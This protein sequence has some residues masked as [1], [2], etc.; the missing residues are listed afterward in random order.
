VS[1]LAAGQEAMISTAQLAS[2]GLGSAAIVRRVRHGLLHRAAELVEPTA[3]KL[4]PT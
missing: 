3:A 2:A 4:L 1:A